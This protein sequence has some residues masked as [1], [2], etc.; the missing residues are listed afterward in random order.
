MEAI[1]LSF[2]DSQVPARYARGGCAHRDPGNA[3][4][5][6]DERKTEERKID[7]K[8]IDEQKMTD[9][10][11]RILVVDDEP[12]IT[13]DLQL[14]L[15]HQHSPGLVPHL[16]VVNPL[17]GELLLFSLPFVNPAHRISWVTMCTS[18]AGVSRRN[19]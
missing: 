14:V 13:R 10:H 1:F 19:L 2:G 3:V 11:R 6:I 16:L 5:G 8:K 18:T 15:H 12:Q 7:E 17:F 9:E 4:S